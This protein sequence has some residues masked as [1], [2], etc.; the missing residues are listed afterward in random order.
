MLNPEV[1]EAEGPQ[2]VSLHDE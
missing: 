1:T 2:L